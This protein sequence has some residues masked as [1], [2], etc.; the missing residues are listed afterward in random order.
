VSGHAKPLMTS[1]V[2][3]RAILSGHGKRE[4]PCP[5][6]ACFIRSQDFGDAERHVKKAVSVNSTASTA[7][8]I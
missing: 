5:R 3:A 8:Q 4:R 1:A 7:Q 6:S 2:R